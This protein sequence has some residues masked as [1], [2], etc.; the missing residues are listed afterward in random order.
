MTRVIL[1]IPFVLG[2]LACTTVGPG[3]ASVSM[4]F[5]GNLEPLG[6]GLWFTPCCL[7]DNFDLRQRNWSAKFNAI[8][9]DGMPVYTSESIVT[10]RIA[11]TELVSLDREVGPNYEKTVIAPILQSTL[12]KIVG[13]YKWFQLDSAGI[14]NCQSEMTSEATVLLRPY[15]IILDGVDIRNI[16]PLASRF[17]SEVITTAEWEQAALK[18]KTRVK[19]AKEKALE[20]VQ[21][22]E[23]ILAEHKMIR[24]GLSRQVLENSATSNWERLLTSPMVSVDYNEDQ[25]YPLEEILQ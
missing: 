7:V 19:I 8:T 6:E 1:L 17:N 23:G 15:H 14:K 25:N 22:A 12:R 16:L 3:R 9:A 21:E 2:V 5:N 11:K 13:K 20:R 4:D 10:Y 18:E 24:S